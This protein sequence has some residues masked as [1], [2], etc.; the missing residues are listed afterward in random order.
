MARVTLS[1]WHRPCLLK[2]TPP[3]ASRTVFSP[4]ELSWPKSSGKSC[5]AKLALAVWQSWCWAMEVRVSWAETCV[6]LQCSSYS[7]SQ[8]ASLA[9][10]K[11]GRG[12]DVKLALASGNPSSVVYWKPGLHA[13]DLD[14]SPGAIAGLSPITPLRPASITNAGVPFAEWA[15]SAVDP[16]LI[17]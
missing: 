3:D 17:D 16:A 5:N 8:R 12:F 9:W 15:G 1:A 13:P 14:D 2:R 4:A 6:R 11:G 7:P 10:F